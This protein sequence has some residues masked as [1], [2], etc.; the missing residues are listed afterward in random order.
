MTAL[1]RWDISKLTGNDTVLLP[2]EI[3]FGDASESQ[4][5]FRAPGINALRLLVTKSLIMSKS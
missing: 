4:G 5:K 3:N 2:F 1:Y